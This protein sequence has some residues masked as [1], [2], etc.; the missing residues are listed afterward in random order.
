LKLNR[1][2]LGMLLGLVGVLMFSL[3][4]PLTRLAVRQIDPVWLALARCSLAA[5]IAGFALMWFK[6]PFPKRDLWPKIFWTIIGVIFGFPIF[7]SISMKFTDASHGAVIAGLLPLTT[8]IIATTFSREKP[9]IKFWITAFAGS[10]LVVG[11]ALWQSKGTLQIGDLAMLLAVLAASTGYALGG[12]LAQAIGGWQ[13]IS[14][15]LVIA[16]PLVILGLLLLSWLRG[17]FFESITVNGTGD[18]QS[19]SWQNWAC[20]GYVA[21]FSQLIGFFFWYGGMAI[22]GVA[23]VSQVQLIQLFS[24][25]GFA[26]LINQEVIS[27]GTWVVGLLV[28]MIIFINK[29]AAIRTS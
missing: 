8:A 24:T 10:S 27:Q 19:I 7:S 28:V 6:V 18:W 11:F 29:K 13:A 26:A 15:S 5:L 20:F 9:S 16:M 14:W 17:G 2:N 22:G 1:E 3:T 25:L 23:R 4:L 21:L 12:K